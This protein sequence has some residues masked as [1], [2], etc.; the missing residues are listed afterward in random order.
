[1]PTVG[2]YIAAANR[3]RL[4]A[5]ALSSLATQTRL[6]DQVAIFVNGEENEEYQEVL[7]D[8]KNYLNIEEVRAWG[9]HNP[10]LAKNNALALL[11]TDYATGLDDDDIFL[12]RRIDNFLDRMHSLD[13]QSHILYSDQVLV[14]SRGSR[15][16]RRPEIA[17]LKTLMRGNAIGNQVFAL[18][19]NLIEVKYRN[20]L[21]VIDDYAF[22][23]D[24]LLRRYRAV[25]TMMPD[26]IW[27]R[28]A[29]EKSVSSASEEH[30][31]SSYNLLADEL[32]S[33]NPA[34][35]R[36]FRFGQYEH[37]TT[38]PTYAEAMAAGRLGRYLTIRG[39][40]WLGK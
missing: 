36:K 26:Y 20:G 9:Q 11:E 27:D 18:R 5:R 39:K 23:I 12:P 13:P 6:P 10:G 8:S 17:T 32:T 28:T 4:L 3:P 2:V 19:K 24:L 30:F 21:R 35:G 38:P 29:A 37:T 40:R 34:L 25:S 31:A 16:V 7:L 22:N 1:M 14:T 33:I 15:I